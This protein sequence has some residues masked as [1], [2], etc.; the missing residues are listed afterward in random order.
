M[1]VHVLPLA[2]AVARKSAFSNGAKI[3]G[4]GS[5]A[6]R[7]QKMRASGQRPR[8]Q[9]KPMYTDISL[10]RCHRRIAFS[11]APTIRHRIIMI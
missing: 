4:I 3:L 7:Y 9:Q 8:L 6:D 11:T 5:E 1:V 10:E 2:S